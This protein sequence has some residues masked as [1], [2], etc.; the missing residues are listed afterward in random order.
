MSQ[1]STRF[2]VRFRSLFDEGRGLAFPC[3]A[4]GRVDL[5][6]LSDK[7]RS[8]Y[9]FARAMVGREYATPC[10]CPV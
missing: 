3:D 6:G 4:D 1:H 5:D 8:N 2:E 7:G 10:V 9:L